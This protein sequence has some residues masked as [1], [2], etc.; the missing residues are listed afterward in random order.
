MSKKKKTDKNDALRNRFAGELFVRVDEPD[1]DESYMVAFSDPGDL[2][3]G[4]VI[5]I[6]SLT[7]VVRVEKTAAIDFVQV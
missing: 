7:S 2:E 5:G 6:Y 3:N 4:D 1:T